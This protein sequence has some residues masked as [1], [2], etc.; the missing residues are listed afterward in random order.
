VPEAIR[1][2]V[3]QMT[4]LSANAAESMGFDSK[5]LAKARARNATSRIFRSRNTSASIICMPFP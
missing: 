2:M 5:A 3:Q 1:A 4:A